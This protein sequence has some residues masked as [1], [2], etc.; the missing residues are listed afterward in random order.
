M[1]LSACVCGG[2]RGFGL[3]LRVYENPKVWGAG[4][5]NKNLLLQVGA[6]RAPR[7]KS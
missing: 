4:G 5:V 6:V 1:F 3:R 2:G 7:L